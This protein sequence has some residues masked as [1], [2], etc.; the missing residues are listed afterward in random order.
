MGNETPVWHCAVC[1]KRVSRLLGMAAAVELCAELTRVQPAIRGFCAQHRDAVVEAYRRELEA[2][3]TI[4]WW[5]EELAELRP[6]DVDAFLFDADQ[7]L[8]SFRMPGAPTGHPTS[9]D[10]PQCGGPVRWGMGPHTEDAAAR[11]NAIAWE[12]TSCGAAGLAYLTK[13]RGVGRG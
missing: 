1:G 5:G 9:R 11:R 13:E 12:C 3:G 4:V 10:C 8:G 2:E 7:L 6:R